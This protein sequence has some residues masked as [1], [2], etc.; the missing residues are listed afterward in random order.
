MS[1]LF[2]KASKKNARLRGVFC[3]TAGS[4][5]SMTCLKTAANLTPPGRRFCAIDTERGS[6]SKYSD[7]FDFDVV[8][9]TSFDQIH[10]INLL[11]MAASEGYYLCVI[12]S[13]SHFWTGKDGE[14]DKVDAITKR[15]KSGN[16]WAA[17]RDVSPLHNQM[18]DAILGSEMHIL[19]TLRVKT[20]YVVEENERGKSAPKKVGLQPIQRDGLDYE[21]DIV[22]DIDDN[23]TLTIGKTRCIP[24]DGKVFHRPDKEF[25]DIL[26]RWLTDGMPAPATIPVLGG[27][28]AVLAA[29]PNQTPTAATT[30]APAPVAP[31]P[32]PPPPASHATPVIVLPRIPDPEMPR[33]TATQV[34]GIR[35]AFAKLSGGE[36]EVISAAQR[37]GADRIEDISSIQADELLFKLNQMIDAESVFGHGADGPQVVETPAEATQEPAAVAVAS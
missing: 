10:L 3:G 32:T 26:R 8:E 17:W 2:Q 16:S 29:R 31:V 11:G 28:S 4:G 27:S 6:L 25:A 5:K 18:V 23:H 13:L 30:P 19:A 20:A 14:L 12:D 36:S 15:S 35:A 1:S 33:A 7:M 9:L 37:R 21:F 24:L 34:V 22:G